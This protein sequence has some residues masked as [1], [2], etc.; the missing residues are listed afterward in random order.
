[1]S[2][3]KLRTHCFLM[4]KLHTW[5][6]NCWGDITFSCELHTWAV[7]S[8]WDKIFPC[9]SYT[10]EL[11]KSEKTLDSHMKFAH[12]ISWGDITFSCELHTWAVKS[13][14][15]ITFS[16]ESIMPMGSHK[17]MSHYV[18]MWKLCPWVNL[19]SWVDII[20]SC[21]NCPREG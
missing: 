8:W 3:H 5:A 19:I 4:W 7:I 2:S 10:H 9:Q 15:A 20:F 6:F 11:S 13:R 14:W 21:E 12:I 17:L 1:M 18:F 16:C